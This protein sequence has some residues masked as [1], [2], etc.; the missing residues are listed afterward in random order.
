M[1]NHYIFL[2]DLILVLHFTIAAFVVL[3]VPFIWIAHFRGMAIARAAWFRCGHLFAMGYVLFQV[4]LGNICPLTSLE[5]SLRLKGG[6]EVYAG[7]FIQH[8][9]HRF[10]FFEAAEGTFLVAYAGFFLIV[11]FTMIW[12]RP[13]FGEHA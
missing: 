7:S 5:S 12:I 2:A 13:R 1:Y 9:I 10:L 3:G 11:A 4:A 8:W 6:G